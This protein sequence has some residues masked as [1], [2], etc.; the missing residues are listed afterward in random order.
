MIINQFYDNKAYGISIFCIMDRMGDVITYNENRLYF[1]TTTLNTYYGVIIILWFAAPHLWCRGTTNVVPH[2]RLIFGGVFVSSIFYHW[3]YCIIN[4]QLNLFQ[5]SKYALPPL[6]KKIEGFGHNVVGFWWLN[7]NHIRK[8]ASESPR[9][10][11]VDFC[12][13]FSQS[14][15]P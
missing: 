6:T 3:F 8:W 11:V 9:N 14:S 4:N 5:S 7:G 10:R 12:V 13:W 1:S 15:V 2:I